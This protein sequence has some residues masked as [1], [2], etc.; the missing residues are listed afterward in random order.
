MNTTVLSTKESPAV[1]AHINMM[2]GIINRMASNSANCKVWCIT[3]SS[4]IFGLF[5]EN[6]FSHLEYLYFIVCLFYFLDSFYL[7]LERKFVKEQKEYVQNINKNEWRKVASQTFLPDAIQVENEG[8]CW[9]V[10][11]GK[12]SAMQLWGI[13][14]ASMSFS[15]MPFYCPF[16]CAIYC[17][18]H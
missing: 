1:Q 11:K 14:K 6:K 8:V 15:T 16:L 3:I 2:Q 7:G 5:C 9:V 17:L 13:V 4:A 10:E 18:Q 12:H